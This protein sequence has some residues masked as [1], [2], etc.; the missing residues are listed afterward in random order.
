[1]PITYH[2]NRNCKP[3]VC[4]Y[5]DLTQKRENPPSIL[6]SKPI[7]SYGKVSQSKIQR[8]EMMKQIPRAVKD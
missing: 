5:D 8:D 2:A 7:H 4:T 6:D 1:V 3:V